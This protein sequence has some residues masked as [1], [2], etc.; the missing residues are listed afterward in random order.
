MLRGVRGF[1]RPTGKGASYVI[2]F[3]GF[4]AERKRN[5]ACERTGSSRVDRNQ[6]SE[7]GR[8]EL[9]RKAI[10]GTSLSGGVVIA[11]GGRG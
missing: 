7:L 9:T 8:H 2:Q 10:L 11:V 6:E 4:L 3:V 1:E 5:F